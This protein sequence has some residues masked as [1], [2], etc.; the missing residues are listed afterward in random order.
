LA[1]AYKAFVDTDTKDSARKMGPFERKLTYLLIDNIGYLTTLASVVSSVA[2]VAFGHYAL[3]GA[4]LATLGF[5]FLVEKG[6]LPYRVRQ[7]FYKLL[8]PASALSL[9]VSPNFFYKICGA[10]NIGM[11][12]YRHFNGT[13][14]VALE[15]QVNLDNYQVSDIPKGLNPYGVVTPASLMSLNMDHLE[16]A[17]IP[18]DAPNVSYDDLE[19]LVDS[20]TWTPSLTESLITK[21]TDDQ[22]WSQRVNKNDPKEAKAYF[23]KCFK[24]FLDRVKNKAILA[25]QP[26]SYDAFE[27]YLKHTIIM[28]KDLKDKD[29]EQVSLILLQ[30]GIEG[31]YCGP[32]IFR[33]VE[34]IFLSLLSHHGKLNFRQR[35][36]LVLQLARLRVF[37]ELY[38]TITDQISNKRTMPELKEL[39]KPDSKLPPNPGLNDY[40]NWMS[41]KFKDKILDFSAAVY[42]TDDVHLYNLCIH[43]FG[44]SFGLPTLSADNDQTIDS[45][46]PLSEE[47]FS[48]YQ[49]LFL[50]YLTQT[51][52]QK[53]VSEVYEAWGT[54]ILPAIEGDNE[55]MD[56]VSGRDAS[57]SQKDKQDAYMLEIGNLIST[58]VS[59]GKTQVKLK[60]EI[61][62]SFLADIGI[63]NLSS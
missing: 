54:P 9:L 59:G 19:A 41:A 17:I 28:L 45:G 57:L 51:Y 55:L 31:V 7:I 16:K 48:K 34:D 21:L 44:N 24:D 46:N 50:P 8:G 61:I 60:N 49:E 63:Y 37:Q 32:G 15:N 4:S 62:P 33:V 1:L 36:Y 58:S 20:I 53:V 52:E 43:M 39:L 27:V 29:P 12:L 2:L 22:R 25:G 47:I 5:G 10:T 11:H 26:M 42:D 14:A 38:T 6:Y 35:I 3:G 23:K 40:W 13:G 56:W 18:L 30:L